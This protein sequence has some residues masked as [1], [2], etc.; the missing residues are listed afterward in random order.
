MKESSLPQPRNALIDIIKGL[1]ILLVV[2]G[3]TEI[4][5]KSFICSFHMPLFFIA[6]GM[7]YYYKANSW[8]HFVFRKAKGLYFPHVISVF[9][10]A[11]LT[12]FLVSYNILDASMHLSLEGI[13]KKCVSGIFFG[14]GGILLLANWFFRTLFF[15]LL[16]YEVIVRIEIEILHKESTRLRLLAGGFFMTIAWLAEAQIGKGEYL[17]FLGVPFFIEYGRLIQKHGSITSLMKNRIIVY[18]FLLL[19]LCFLIYAS[20]IHLIAY[21]RFDI[22]NPLWLVLCSIVGFELVYIISRIICKT[23]KLKALF[24]LMGKNSLWIML[25]HVICFKFVTLCEIFYYDANMTLLSSHP[26]WINNGVWWILYSIVGLFGPLLL[27]NMFAE[28]KKM[29][30][31][32]IV[33]K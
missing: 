24:C 27:I 32:S 33:H 22:V 30:K 31:L 28:V 2:V 12:N 4:P 18:F 19:G 7:C 8:K 17:N 16:L 6:S 9:C 14:G 23:K 25:L 1:G 11:V 15:G 3:H 13:I 10:V 26:V 29:I 21:N 5:I 20:S